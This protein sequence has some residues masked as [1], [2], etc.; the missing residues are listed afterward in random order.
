VSEGGGRFFRYGCLG[1]VG[2]VVLCL[3]GITML[4]ALGRGAARSEKITTERVEEPLP[5]VAPE[6]ETPPPPEAEEVPPFSD[7]PGL[8]VP[9]FPEA[10]A[11]Q[12]P[13]RVL[14]DLSHGEFEVKPAGPGEPLRVEAEYDENRYELVTRLD[15]PPEGEWSY[16]VRFRQSGPTGFMFLLA[17]LFGARNPRVV[18]SLPR[19]V[20]MDL[21]LRFSQGGGRADLGGLWL[22]DTKVTFAE[23]GGELEFSEPLREPTDTLS[24]EASMGGGSFQRIGNASPRELRVATSMGGG[25]VDLRGQW[26]RDCEVSL[27]SSMGGLNVRLPADANVRGV[28][29]RQGAPEEEQAGRPT[30]DLSYSASMGEIKFQ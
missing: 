22:T 21:D 1:C 8:P 10:P 5:G 4:V 13:G 11:E 20:P 2:I 18:V 27:G 12:R 26:R 17:R 16:E 29:G 6:I 23:G 9:D 25:E 24:I 28:P 3:A 14:V 15:E 30:L 19:D 7:A